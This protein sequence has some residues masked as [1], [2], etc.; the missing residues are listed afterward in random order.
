M[1]FSGHDDSTI[2]IVLGLLLL[3]LLLFYTRPLSTVGE[4]NIHHYHLLCGHIS[5]SHHK[6]T[7]SYYASKTYN[8]LGH[9]MRVR[10]V[11]GI[12]A[13]EDESPAASVRNVRLGDVYCVIVAA[14]GSDNTGP[15]LIGHDQPAESDRLH[16]TVAA[17]VRRRGEREKE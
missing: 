8:F 15:Q 12:G 5:Y 17:H 9:D 11:V 1:T 13:G 3:L 10:T 7:K 16:T 4:Y 6:V 2:N 14:V